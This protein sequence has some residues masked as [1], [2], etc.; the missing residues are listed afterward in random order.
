[1]LLAMLLWWSVE[2]HSPHLAP[3]VED[4]KIAYISD[5]GAHEL[6]PL[7]IAMGSVTVVTFDMVFIAERWLR[8]RGTLAVNTSWFQ[9]GLSIAATVCA[10]AGAAGL[11]LLTC[12]NDLY[13]HTAHDTCLVIFIAG[14][15]LSAIFICWEYH[16]LGVHHRRHRILRVSFY[17]KL[18][19]IIVEVAL[20][21]AFGALGDRKRYNPA[22]VVE[23][24]I[25]LVFTFYVWSFA[26]DFIPAVRIEHYRNKEA[27]TEMGSAMQ[28][29]A[30]EQSWAGT[31]ANAYLDDSGR[32]PHRVGNT[33]IQPGEQTRR[34]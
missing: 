4:Q 5:I 31:E 7:F 14:Y 34:N 29:E 15:I 10:I 9:K 32:A 17:I 13:H 24:T 22:A 18:M 30:A 23:W 27:D 6:Q 20:C 16:R 19:F 1:M 26:I 8:H 21:I 3:M 12:L 2:K 33:R 28:E 25:S 11:I